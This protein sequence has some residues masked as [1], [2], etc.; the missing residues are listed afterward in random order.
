MISKSTSCT[1]KYIDDASQ[2][3]SIKLKKALTKIDISDRPRPLEFFEHTGFVLNTENN[4]LQEDI[5]N[6]KVF[7]EENLMVINQKKTIIMSFNFRKS[8]DFP[9][10]F[11]IGDGPGLD[12]GSDKVTRQYQ[13]R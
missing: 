11:R 1:V 10:I 5:D 12:I 9:P 3:R 6:L 13:P 2:A 8:L 4:E 7:T